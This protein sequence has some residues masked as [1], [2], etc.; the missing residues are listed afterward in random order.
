MKYKL[1]KDQQWIPK[2]RDA[3]EQSLK[4]APSSAEGNICMGMVDF[5]A[6]KYEQAASEFQLAIDTDPTNA[7]AYTEVGFEHTRSL[8]GG[9]R[10]KKPIKKRSRHTPRTHRATPL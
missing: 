1:T 3:C 8:G 5:G 2:M 10:R 9:S 4:L 7:L 6:G